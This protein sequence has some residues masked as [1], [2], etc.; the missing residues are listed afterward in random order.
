MTLVMERQ[1]DALLQQALVELKWGVVRDLLRGGVSADSREHVMHE[2]L[3][4]CQWD[5]ITQVVQQGVSLHHR[6]MALKEALRHCQWGCVSLVIKLGVSDE[7]RDLAFLKAVRQRQWECVEDMLAL[8][9]SQHHKTL[10]L[11]RYSGLEQW[12]F[13]TELAQAGVFTEGKLQD[14]LQTRFSQWNSVQELIDISRTLSLEQAKLGMCEVLRLNKWKHVPAL[15]KLCDH[16]DVRDSVLKTAVQQFQWDCVAELTTLNLTK[17][18]RRYVCNELIVWGQ[19]D[20][21]INLLR[22]GV[23]PSQVTWIV[24]EMLRQNKWH[25][26]QIMM[27]EGWKPAKQLKRL[28]LTSAVNYRQSNVYTDIAHLQGVTDHELTEVMAMAISQ[29]A[30][31]FLHH[32][33]SNTSKGCRVFKQ[34]CLRDHLPDARSLDVCINLLAL[35]ETDLAFFLAATQGMWQIVCNEFADSRIHKR[36][37]SFAFRTAVK[38][39]EWES[40]IRMAKCGNVSKWDMRFA[41]LTAVRQSFWSS[42]LQLTQTGPVSLRNDEIRSTVKMCLSRDQSE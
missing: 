12:D 30:H 35:Q 9:V 22:D 32:V 23:E 7:Q 11:R 40:V 26:V 37:R 41:F 24:H 6:D 15:F 16:A 25:L 10:A 31:A 3:K 38:H 29:S 14:S 42:A 21:A 27:R 13:T 2:A 17:E 33:I 19:V 36:S 1:R 20:C 8:G 4:N 28:L 5:C 39:G 34:L 18:Q